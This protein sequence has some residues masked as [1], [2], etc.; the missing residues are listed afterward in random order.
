MSMDNKFL[1]ILVAVSFLDIIIG[2]INHPTLVIGKNN[3]ID[4]NQPMQRN[5]INTSSEIIMNLGL[6]LQI[7]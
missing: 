5:G 1:M 7:L 6:A 2:Y 3:F 4:N